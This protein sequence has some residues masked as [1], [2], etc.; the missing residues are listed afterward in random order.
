[1]EVLEGPVI[2]P[3]LERRLEGVRKGLGGEGSQPDV[4][5]LGVDRGREFY[6]EAGTQLRAAL[7]GKGWQN[8]MMA[9]SDKV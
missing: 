5:S 2:V 1:M 6:A 8:G 7:Q 9:L 4:G 3:E